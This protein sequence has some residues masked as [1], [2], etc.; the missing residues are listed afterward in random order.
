MPKSCWPGAEALAR[1]GLTEVSFDLTMPTMAAMLL[2]SERADARSAARHS[3][4]RWTARTPP[5]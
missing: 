4:M 3:P 5:P 1:L 2:D